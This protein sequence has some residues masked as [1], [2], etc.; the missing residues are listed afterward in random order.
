MLKSHYKRKIAA[1]AFILSLVFIATSGP[2]FN[3]TEGAAG[4]AGR[5]GLVLSYAGSSTS[6][7]PSAL[8]PEISGT[9]VTSNGSTITISGQFTGDASDIK[10]IG[11]F[12]KKGASGTETKFPCSFSLSGN[13]YVIKFI[14]PSGSN[15]N[16]FFV[17][18][19]IIDVDGGIVRMS[20]WIQI[21]YSANPPTHWPDQPTDPDSNKKSPSV[22]TEGIR[23]VHLTGAEVVIHITDTGNATIDNCGVVISDSNNKPTIGHS[24]SWDY[25]APKSHNRG[26]ATVRV[27]GLKPYTRYYVRAYAENR[28]GTSYGEVRTFVTD[29]VYG[30]YYDFHKGYIHDKHGGYMGDGYLFDPNDP[31]YL[32]YYFLNSDVGTLGEVEVGPNSATVHGYI[33]SRYNFVIFERGFVYS[34]ST[35]MPNINDQRV[36]DTRNAVGRYSMNLSGLA[37]NTFYY[38]RAYIRTNVGLIYGNP[39]SFTTGVGGNPGGGPGAYGQGEFVINIHFTTYGGEIV[40]RQTINAWANQRLTQN[41]LFPPAGYV[42]HGGE[43]SYVVARGADITA[44]VARS[45]IA[46]MPSL[47]GFRFLPD[48]PIT[49]GEV[50]QMIFNLS[51]NRSLGGGAMSFGDTTGSSYKEAIDFVSSHRIMIGYPDGSFKPNATITRAEMAVVLNN[52]YKLEGP[53]SSP[54]SDLPQSHWAYQYVAMA[55]S[56]GLITGYPDGTFRPNND[57]TR[58]EACVLFSK[59]E[60]RDLMHLGNASFT[61]VPPSHWAYDYIMSAAI[62]LQ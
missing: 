50:A 24:F 19:Y 47:G 36:F 14:L 16:D 20:N 52:Y 38:V 13:N 48:N 40:G 7:T 33:N 11:V 39:V 37:G 32:D 28:F 60:K 55:A 49:R 46:F 30:W 59:A 53:Y 22:R 61:D 21:G 41:D 27:T 2:L 4:E 6:T 62:P 17:Q 42:I 31:F 5:P 12:Y 56:A 58:A 9:A 8:I 57:N 51:S 34:S 18:A 45:R 43:W 54:F 1:L 35:D 26:P 3:S 44:I 29:G 23:N 25:S 15:Y 10:E